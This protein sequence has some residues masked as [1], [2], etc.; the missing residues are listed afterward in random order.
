VKEEAVAMTLYD[1]GIC[2][3]INICIIMYIY[4]YMYIYIYIYISQI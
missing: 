2:T 1:N 4:V 3:N